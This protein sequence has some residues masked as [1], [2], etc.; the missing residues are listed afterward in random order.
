MLAAGT[1][2]VTGLALNVVVDRVPDRQALG[3]FRIRCPHCAGAGAWLRT[4]RSCELCSA[5][6]PGRYAAVPLVTAGLFAALAVRIGYEWALPAF[7]AFAATL[8]AVSVADLQAELIPNRILYPGGA[9]TFAL[10]VG[11]A[12]AGA[13]GD[14]LGRA[15]VAAGVSWLALLALHLLSPGGMGFGDVRLSFLLGLGLGWLG[16]RHVVAGLALGVLLAGA[17]ATALIA[18]GR[19]SRTA[20]VP[21]GPFLAAGALL[22]VLLLP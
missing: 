12:V 17:A 11:A 8:V 20:H 22:A 7:L 9:A 2:I 1:G 19:R 14:A 4:A 5:P 16:Y 18:S 3:P 21:L 13:Q 10:L 6:L 15:L